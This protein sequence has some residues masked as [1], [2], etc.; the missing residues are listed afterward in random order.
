MLVLR[1]IHKALALDAGNSR[2]RGRGKADARLCCVKL[3]Q[4]CHGVLMLRNL[5]KAQAL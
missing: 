5:D 3:S 2:N 4:G 1:N